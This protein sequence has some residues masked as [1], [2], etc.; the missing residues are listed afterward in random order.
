[1]QTAEGIK[2]YATPLKLKKALTKFDAT[3]FWKLPA[4]VYVLQPPPPSM[5]REAIAEAHRVSKS[6][7]T[8]HID[9][10]TG[11]RYERTGRLSKH[12]RTVNPRVL[13]FAKIK[14]AA[15]AARIAA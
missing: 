15:R 11:E 5:T 1:V 14:K 8:R 10:K 4:G 12:K 3:G 2:R 6:R 9:P 13:E 7:L